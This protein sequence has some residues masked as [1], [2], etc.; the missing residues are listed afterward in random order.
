MKIE[1]VLQTKGVE[2]F[3]VKDTDT[4]ASAVSLLNKKNI[5]AVVVKDANQSVVGILSE[6]DIVRRLGEDGGDA[7]QLRAKDCMTPNPFTCGPEA[8]ID[9]VLGLMTDKR[10]RHVPVTKGGKLVGVVSIG[11]IVKR[12]IDMAVKEAEA[13]KDYIVS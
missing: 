3:A 12:K 9:D 7:L 5:G 13:L 6:R 11:D 1:Q 4:I 10:V 8:T 2:V